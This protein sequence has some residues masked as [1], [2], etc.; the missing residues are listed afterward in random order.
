VHRSYNIGIYR[1]LSAQPLD[2][3]IVTKEPFECWTLCVADSFA[4]G[5][6]V[7]IGHEPFASDDDA[8]APPKYH[9]EALFRRYKI[10]HRGKIRVAS[11]EEVHGLEEVKAYF[12]KGMQ[13]L[14][15]QRLVPNVPVRAKAENK[16]K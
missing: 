15:R 7:V 10:W 8:W 2:A 4:K 3:D 1:I 14:I 11:A 6:W 9:Y 12:A 16:G 13:L 5:N